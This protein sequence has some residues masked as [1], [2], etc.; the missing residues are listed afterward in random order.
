MVWLSVM[1][2]VSSCRPRKFISSC[3]FL[4]VATDE[5]YVRVLDDYKEVFLRDNP[6]RNESW[7]VNEHMRKFIGWLRYWISQSNTHPNEYLK[8]LF[9]DHIFTIVTYQWYDIN[10][11]MFYI[12]QQDKKITHQNSGVHVDAYD[13]SREYKHVVWSNTRDLGIWLSRFQDS[14]FPLQLSWCNQE[15]CKRQVRVH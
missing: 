5:H 10:G 3:S 14:S 9:R 4:F 6:E 1:G 15:C 7:L 11:Y 8:K 13:V 2:L 12:E